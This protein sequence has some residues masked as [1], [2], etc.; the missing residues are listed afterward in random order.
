MTTDFAL[1]LPA[2]NSTSTI[3][4]LTDSGLDTVIVTPSGRFN[5]YD[6]QLKLGFTLVSVAFIVFSI[7][8][9]LALL[10]TKRTPENSR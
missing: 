6:F 4:S 1:S 7:I 9:L 10:R 5:D 8:A 3:S 2:M